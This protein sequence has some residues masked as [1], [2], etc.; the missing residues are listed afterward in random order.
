MKMKKS[1]R[2]YSLFLVLFLCLLCT[3]IVHTN[4]GTKS[5]KKLI[6]GTWESISGSGVKAIFKGEKVKYYGSDGNLFRQAKIIKIVKAN[7]NGKGYIVRMKDKEFGKY[8][9]F[10]RLNDTNSM[11][12]YTNWNARGEEA[13]KSALI[14]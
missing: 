12:Y 11:H 2:I 14:R 1:F 3:P 6:Q 5:A 9:Y 4:A 10:L 13:A 8:C 7:R